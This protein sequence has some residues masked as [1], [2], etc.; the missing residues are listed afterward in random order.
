MKSR[1]I[2]KTEA[3]TRIELIVVLAMGDG[4]AQRVTS[5]S[6]KNI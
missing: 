1:A 6:F 3:I 2:D 5:G 4:S